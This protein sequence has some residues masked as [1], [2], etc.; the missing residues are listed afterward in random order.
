M[1]FL[2]GRFLEGEIDV[3][4]SK[5]QT[6]TQTDSINER[7]RL[8]VLHLKQ[9]SLLRAELRRVSVSLS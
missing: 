1:I 3:T 2:K 5:K 9:A 8:V 6:D 7:I 4:T